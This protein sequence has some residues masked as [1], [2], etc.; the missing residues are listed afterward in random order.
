M[1][2]NE[3]DSTGIVKIHIEL[4]TLLEKSA[5]AFGEGTGVF[6]FA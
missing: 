4:D 3:E 2:L 6:L 5:V 1:Q